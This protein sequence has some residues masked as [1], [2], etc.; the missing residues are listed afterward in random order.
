MHSMGIN[1]L[2]LVQVKLDLVKASAFFFWIA[3]GEKFYCFNILVCLLQ[4]S[5]YDH[6]NV[7]SLEPWV[8][9]FKTTSLLFFSHSVIDLLVYL[10][11][12]FCCTIHFSLCFS[13]WTDVL[14][15]FQNELVKR[16]IHRGLNDCKAYRSCG[17]KTD[18]NSSPCLSVGMRSF[19][20]LHTKTWHCELKPDKSTLVL[21]VQRTVFQTS[22]GSIRCHFVNLSHAAMFFFGERWLSP[23][24]PSMKAIF[25]QSNGGVMI[26]NITVL[27]KNLLFP[28]C[29]FRVTVFIRALHGLI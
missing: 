20:A 25:V 17:F 22:C 11:S 7:Y 28:G 9:H 21:S 6:G 4:P 23:G 2:Y 14:T 5:I 16:G 18:P 29:S 10:G 8:S 12:L 27:T 1:F 24:Y 26:S 19:W 3:L 13:C 15:F